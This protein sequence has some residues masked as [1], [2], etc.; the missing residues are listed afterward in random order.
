MFLS[1]SN[2]QSLLSLRLLINVHA[3]LCV[4]FR[5]FFFT[6]LEFHVINFQHFHI[7]TFF[8]LIYKK[9]RLLIM[10]TIV[11]ISSLLIIWNISK[12]RA[13]LGLLFTHKYS[14]K[15]K[16][17]YLKNCDQCLLICSLKCR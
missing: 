1:V 13:F 6:T 8:L 9:S 4:F 10:I 16:Y 12:Q 11:I 2:S 17:K 7:L 15:H 3:H 5:P 14:D